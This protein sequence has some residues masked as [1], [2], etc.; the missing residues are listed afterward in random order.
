MKNRFLL[1]AALCLGLA[2]PPEHLYAQDDIA[3]LEAEFQTASK[4]FAAQLQELRKEGK[5]RE[6]LNAFSQANNPAKAFIARYQAGAKA[7]A[8]KDAA[9]PYLSWIGA[10]GARVD[11]QAAIDAWTTVIKDHT[12]S[13]HIA[14]AVVAISRMA[15]QIGGDKV[16]NMISAVI[17]KNPN[18]A[19]RI[20][21][22]FSRAEVTL[23]DKEA[24]DEARK[25]AIEDFKAVVAS[26]AN[27]ALARRAE[28]QL[29]VLEN[30][31]IGMTAPDI[32]ANDL[33]GVEF[34][35]SDYR[36]KVVVLDFW[37]DW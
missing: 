16:R 10:N 36:G 20:Q 3:T 32:I 25:Q 11:A 13:P 21:A 33:D 30:L 26:D 8:G 37:G 35:L 12:E 22:L 2:S 18:E 17:D 9:I 1:G 29:F 31:Q 28:G 14:P 6:E 34:K 19:I 23:Q 7:N 24:S 15:G 5:S 27:P 4:A